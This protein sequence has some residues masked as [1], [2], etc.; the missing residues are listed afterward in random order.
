MIRA[1]GRRLAAVAFASTLFVAP[2]TVLAGA[3]PTICCVCSCSSGSVCSE[4]F[5]EACPSVCGTLPQGPCDFDIID[6][7][8]CAGVSVCGLG[9]VAPAP[10][11]GGVGLTVAGGALLGLAA[12]GIRRR[13]G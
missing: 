10:A 5:F 6:A 11:L 12:L 2:A 1:L 7:E 13:Q 3:L 9:S 8:T 4:Q